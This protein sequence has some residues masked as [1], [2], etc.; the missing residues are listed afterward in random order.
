MIVQ[1]GVSKIRW[2]SL[3]VTVIAGSQLGH[4]I[5]YAVRYGATNAASRES[6]GAHLYYPAL[7]GALSGIVGGALMTCMIVLAVAR[8]LRGVS[9]GLRPRRSVRVGDV[10]PALFT[11]QLLLFVGQETVECLIGGA[12][13]PSPIEELLWAVFGQLPAALLAAIVISW[14]S[15]RMEAAWA[16]LV[17]A[18]ARLLPDHLTAAPIAGRAPAAPASP[19]PASTFLRAIPKRGP[20][21]LRR[22]TVL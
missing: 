21:V 11:A 4:A 15:T 12:A 22:A 5:T 20:P 8:V 19:A 18:V 10:L 13:I 16:V 9:P 14:L 3:I 7:S 17:E 2:L 6:A 1:V